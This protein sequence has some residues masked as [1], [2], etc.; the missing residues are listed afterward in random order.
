M[1]VPVLMG[2]GV[3][4]INI[5][6]WR[7]N[8]KVVWLANVSQIY[9]LSEVPV[10]ECKPANKHLSSATFYANSGACNSTS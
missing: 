1:F 7:L 9:P 2:R 3:R 4:Y 5:S 8:A 6:C 10:V